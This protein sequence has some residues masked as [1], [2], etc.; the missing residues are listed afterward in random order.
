MATQFRYDTVPHCY[1]EPPELMGR[2][3]VCEL[4]N[5]PTKSSAATQTAPPEETRVK[6]QKG[7]ITT[8][9]T[10]TYPVDFHLAYTK[11]RQIGEPYEF[12]TKST[13]VIDT[14]DA[15]LDPGYLPRSSRSPSPGERLP[16]ACST[17]RLDKGDLA[18]R[19]S[20][21]RMRYSLTPTSPRKSKEGLRKSDE[22]GADACWICGEGHRYSECP[23]E[24]VHIF[25]F[26][27]GRRD[28]TTKTCP[29]CGPQWREEGPYYPGKPS[30]ARRKKN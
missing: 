20:A 3:C 22:K 30:S 8:V 13:T 5:K 29:K 7:S 28:V 14:K 11:Q 4:K 6:R 19:T 24:W 26:R 16:P 10:Q 25:C 9:A 15:S 27:C 17:Q 2:V 21:A 12:L 18:D 23:H 1:S